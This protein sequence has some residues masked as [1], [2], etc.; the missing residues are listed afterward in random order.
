MARNWEHNGPRPDL[1]PWHRANVDPNGD[2]PLEEL[3]VVQR[4]ARH[5]AH[6]QIVERV[7]GSGAAT[8]AEAGAVARIA[9]K[10]AEKRADKRNNT[11]GR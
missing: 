8:V 1:P 5:S 4:E 3:K 9:A 11:K 2:M 6:F 7:K 10:I